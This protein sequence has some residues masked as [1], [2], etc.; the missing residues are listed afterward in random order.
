M[1]KSEE[2]KIKIEKCEKTI[3]VYK[4]ALISG[5]LSDSDYRLYIRYMNEEVEKLNNLKNKL[6]K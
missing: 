1:S 3:E 6:N 2:L 5:N 4:E